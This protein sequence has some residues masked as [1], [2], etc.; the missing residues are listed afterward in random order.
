MSS[1][2]GVKRQDKQIMQLLG[3]ELWFY[4]I[5]LQL[6][7]R[8]IRCNAIAPGF[9]ETNDCKIKCWRCA[10][11]E[12]RNSTEELQMMLPTLAFS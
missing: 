9:I 12:R 10:G 3:R 5:S 11:M 2:V 7:S 1:V 8:N 4:K 6:G